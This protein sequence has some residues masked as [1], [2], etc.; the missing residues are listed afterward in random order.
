MRALLEIDKFLQFIYGLLDIVSE[1]CYLDNFN[2]NL[3]ASVDFSTNKQ[4]E[5]FLN[6]PCADSRNLK[7]IVC[8]FVHELFPA[9]SCTLV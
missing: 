8:H 6:F 4:H 1:F 5:Y 2:N 9:Y 7:H 3:K